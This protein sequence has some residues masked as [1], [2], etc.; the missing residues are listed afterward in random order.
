MRWDHRRDPLGASL[1][2][3]GD[4]SPFDSEDSWSG[5]ESSDHDFREPPLPPTVADPRQPWLDRLVLDP[6]VSDSSPVVRG[7]WV[8]VGHVVSLVVDGW[9]WAD[10]LR[11]H[12]E[13][14][15]DDLR[16]CLTYAV[17]EENASLEI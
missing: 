7:T 10:I 16:A 17:E 9:S 5:R 8:T 6:N 4:Q 14:T 2:L 15:E 1:D 12:P 11:T 3:N 13:L